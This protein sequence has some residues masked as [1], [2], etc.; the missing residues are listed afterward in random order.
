MRQWTACKGAHK[1]CSPK[2]EEQLN[3]ERH[4]SASP[5]KFSTPGVNKR[6]NR[7][8][9]LASSYFGVFP[10]Y[11]SDLIP[12]RQ[13]HGYWDSPEISSAF[14]WHQ[15]DASTFRAPTQAIHRAKYS[16]AVG[17]GQQRPTFGI[18]GI[19]G[20]RFLVS[21]TYGPSSLN[22]HL[23]VRNMSAPCVLK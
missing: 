20:M 16:T 12:F 18:P 4:V 13:L 19:F 21:L 9:G 14:P 23:Q 15:Y 22:C 10:S 11:D 17:G 1:K 5:Y 7:S 2:T 8:P 3:K 6:V